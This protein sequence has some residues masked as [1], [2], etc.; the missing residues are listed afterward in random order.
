MGAALPP[1]VECADRSGLPN[2]MIAP[3]TL[4][5]IEARVTYLAP[6]DGPVRCA[7]IRPRADSPPCARLSPARDADPRRTPDRRPPAARRARVRAAFASDGVR[8]LLRRS[9]GPRAVLPRGAGG[10][11]GDHG[12][13]RG[14]RV[15]PQRAQRGARGPRRAG[16]AGARRPGAQRL[17]RASGPKRKQEILEAAGRSDLADRHV[18][19][20]NLWRPIVGPV[21]DNPLAVCDARSVSPEDLVATD[22]H[23]FGEDDLTTPRH[24]G[25]IYSV[26]YNPAHR[27]FYVSAMRPD[28]VLLL[29]VLRLARG[30]TRAVHAAYRIRN[31][32]ARASSC[33][34]KAS[35]RGRWWCS[36]SAPSGRASPSRGRR[37]AAPCPR[38]RA[39][40]LLAE[41]A[42]RDHVAE[43]DFDEREGAHVR[44]G[45]D[46]H[47]G[48]PA[49]RRGR[50]HQA[51]EERP[52][53][54][55]A[56][57]HDHR[58]ACAPAASRRGAPSGAPAPRRACTPR[59]SGTPRLRARARRR[60]SRPPQGRRALPEARPSSAGRVVQPDTSARS[61][62]ARRSARAASRRPCRDAIAASVGATSSGRR[63]R[64][65]RRARP[66][67]ARSSRTRCRARSCALHHAQEE[68]G[69]GDLA[70]APTTIQ[71]RT[72]RSA[73]ERNSPP[74][75]DRREPR[76]AKG[77]P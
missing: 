33:R 52:A 11:A 54:L 27:W 17:H 10:D 51:G 26:R 5:A 31:P 40:E 76:S 30:R 48:E 65:A 12:R 8:R 9:G 77:S 21:L 4:R 15:R 24:S 62:R 42:P 29:E 60:G 39:G 66:G 53:P 20:V 1:A 22:I 63:G 28:E 43:E 14:D 67:S 23:H 36:T 57:A 19:F 41:E 32:L 37:S 75:R 72:R 50:A 59:P 58:R 71:P 70:T 74:G 56:D 46:R 7:S 35:K 73:R 47:R 38:S 64:R 34:A 6:G 44:R 25:Q 3:E 61:G 68:R 49:R 16:R 45:L 13:A 18:A 55:A 2:W 69:R